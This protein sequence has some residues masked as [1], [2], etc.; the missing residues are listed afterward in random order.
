MGI[1]DE[2]KVAAITNTETTILGMKA[3]IAVLPLKSS[4]A[5][6]MR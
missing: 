2:R 3:T 1:S 6:V 4:S 5:L